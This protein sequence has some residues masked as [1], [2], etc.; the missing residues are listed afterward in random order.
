MTTF[1]FIRRRTWR[2]R[3]FSWPWCPWRAVERVVIGGS[4]PLPRWRGPYEVLA[5]RRN[6]PNGVK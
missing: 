5:D 2:E 3:L 4:K 6:Q 1:I